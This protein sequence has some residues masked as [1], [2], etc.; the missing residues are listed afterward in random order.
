MYEIRCTQCNDVRS[1]ANDENAD[2]DVSD[3]THTPQSKAA[4]MQAHC[5]TTCPQCGSVR[6]GTKKV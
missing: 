2:I 6:F 4:I 3:T 1:I 5:G